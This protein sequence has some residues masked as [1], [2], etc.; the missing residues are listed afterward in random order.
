[1]NV[2]AGGEW[3][4]LVQVAEGWDMT[5]VAKVIMGMVHVMWELVCRSG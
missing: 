4:D 2:W 3:W 1:M 5:T